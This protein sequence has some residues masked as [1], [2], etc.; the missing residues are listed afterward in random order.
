M[1]LQLGGQA[2]MALDGGSAFSFTPA[3]SFFVIC[4]TVEDDAALRLLARV[5]QGLVGR[6]L[7][8]LGD[9]AEVPM[10]T[11]AGTVHAAEG[12]DPVARRHL[13]LI[14]G[15]A[16]NQ[17]LLAASGFPTLDGMQILPRLAER[18]A[19]RVVGRGSGRSQ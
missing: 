19:I 2:F 3:I 13:S 10:R 12:L 8:F 7:E 17:A 14:D 9:M 15:R 18:G 4:P 5:K 1:S 11:E 16:T 6:F